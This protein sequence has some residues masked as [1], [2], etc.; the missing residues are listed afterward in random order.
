MLFEKH[1]VAYEKHSKCVINLSYKLSTFCAHALA[2]KIPHVQFDFPLNKIFQIL[3]K[4]KKGLTHYIQ[5][6]AVRAWSG[7]A[8]S[9][10]PN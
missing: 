9:N 1:S 10:F 5:M 6:K 8:L 7:P 3:K 2:K 4:K